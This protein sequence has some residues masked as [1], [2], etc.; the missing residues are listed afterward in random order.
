MHIVVLAIIGGVAAFLGWLF[1]TPDCRGAVVAT[2]SACVQ[3]PGFDRAFCARAFARPE[4]AIYRAGN[5]FATQADCNVRHPVCITF[6][7]VH[8]WTPT[9]NGYCIIRA[10]D[11][12][13]ASM[14]PVYDK[15]RDAK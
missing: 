12:D 11:G 13:L 6:P 1:L 3:Q 14:T 4:E 5:V 15:S 7:G 2:E 10:A 8:G 9:P